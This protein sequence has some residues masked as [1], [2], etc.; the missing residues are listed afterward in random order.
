[1]HAILLI[2]YKTLSF[3]LTL[4]YFQDKEI[5]SLG[6]TGLIESQIFLK[7]IFL[8]KQLNYF[9]ELGEITPKVPVT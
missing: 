9:G 5:A 1:M 7:I 2:L 4:N 8:L 6:L 3:E